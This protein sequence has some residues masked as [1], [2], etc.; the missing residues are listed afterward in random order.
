M[1]IWWCVDRKGI[2]VLTAILIFACVTSASTVSAA[3]QGKLSVYVV[4]YPLQ[5]FAER[6]GGDHTTVVFPASNEGDPA[7]W[8]PEAKTVSAYQKADIILLNGAN[9]AKWVRKVSL[10]RSRLVN[11]SKKFKDQYIIAD[12]IVTHSHGPGGKHAHESL[13]FTTWLDFN[14]AAKQAKA[15]VNVFSRK[16]PNLNETFQKNFKALEKQLLNID[17]EINSVVSKDPSKLFIGS[18]PVY[19]YFARRYGI[20]MESVHWEPDEIPNDG[21]WVNLQK[22]MKAHPAKWMIWEGDP[23]KESVEKLKTIGIQSLVFDPCGNVPSDGDFL[24]TM[25]QNVKNLS[26]AFH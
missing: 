3:S 23:L 26:T 11:T 2:G 17:H 19:D 8:N 12:D 1:K 6:I 16:R 24:D 13:A 21:Q 5:Y 7:Y 9:Y 14:L 15:I 22:L 10:P 4:N 25:K 20:R 18:H